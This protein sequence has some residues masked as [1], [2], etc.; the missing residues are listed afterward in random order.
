[1]SDMNPALVG[2]KPLFHRQHAIHN[3][4]RLMDESAMVC[5]TR[6]NEVIATCIVLRFQT[7]YL[8]DGLPE[9]LML[10]RLTFSL[11]STYQQHLEQPHDSKGDEQ[12]VVG[13]TIREVVKPNVIDVDI[14]RSAI[15]SLESVAR[16][17]R[18]DDV[19]RYFHEQI[20]QCLLALLSS[21]SD[22]LRVFHGLYFYVLTTPKPSFEHLFCS[23][24]PTARALVAHYVAL[25]QI[26][27]ALTSGMAGDSHMATLGSAV[28]WIYNLCGGRGLPPCS[29]AQVRWP[30]AVAQGMRLATSCGPGERLP[31]S[32]TKLRDFMTQN[33]TA[34][35]L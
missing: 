28:E 29:H 24:C 23:S 35:M 6:K 21:I 14:F 30:M 17:S 18:D 32:N 13:S 16:A 9:L 2:F 33:P 27:A 11:T 22:G 10:L 1:M 12:T 25:L 4:T 3:L 8:A 19:F 26:V 15:A 7:F 5:A 31:L 20:E 34:F